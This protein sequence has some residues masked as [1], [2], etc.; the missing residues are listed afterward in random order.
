M[1]F[2]VLKRPLWGKGFWVSALLGLQTSFEIFSSR[3]EEYVPSLILLCFG[4]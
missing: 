3:I 2:L 1:S 4:F